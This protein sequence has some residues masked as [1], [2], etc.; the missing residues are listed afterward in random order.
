MLN[1][2]GKAKGRNHRCVDAC[3][4]TQEVIES[5]MKALSPFASCWRASEEVTHENCSKEQRPR[6]IWACPGSSLT[7]SFPMRSFFARLDLAVSGTPVG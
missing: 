6:H 2:F 4:R 7:D 3:F 5:G 1:E